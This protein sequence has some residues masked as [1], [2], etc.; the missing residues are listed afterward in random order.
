MKVRVLLA[1]AIAALLSTTAMAQVD[2][3]AVGPAGAGPGDAITITIYPD[4][5]CPLPTTNPNQSLVGA[6]VV[7]LHAGVT[8]ATN[9]WQN[10]V[11]ADNPG[12]GGQAEAIVGFTQDPTTGIWTKTITPNSYFTG[13]AGPIT[14]LN[15]VVNGG[16]EGSRWD[17]EGKMVNV[18]TGACMD[19]SATFPLSGPITEIPSRYLINAGKFIKAVSPNPATTSTQLKYV[20]GTA[21][22]TTV[23][24]LNAIGSEVVTLQ[25]GY[26]AAGEYSIDW[27]TNV[28]PGI[29]YISVSANGRSDS[30]KVVVK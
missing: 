8:V 19:A 12:S 11:S 15:F 16:P 9:I 29:Y 10:V 26:Q 6:T 21:G 25:N 18:N 17:K 5:T 13:V 24:V 1:G 23:R 3:F 7:R 22:N 4:Q 28:T 30:R 14:A 20:L 27:A 2:G